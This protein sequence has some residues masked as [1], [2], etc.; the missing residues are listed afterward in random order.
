MRKNVVLRALRAEVKLSQRDFAKRAKVNPIQLAQVET[1]LDSKSFGAA[2]WLSIWDAFER[3]LVRLG[4]TCQD[5]IR[6]RR[7]KAA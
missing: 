2:G 3:D 1:G 5:L 6:G 7:R 4:Y